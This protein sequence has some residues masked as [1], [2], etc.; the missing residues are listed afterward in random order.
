MLDAL[1]HTESAIRCHAERA[2]MRLL[3]GGCSVPLGVWTVLEAG[4]LKMLGSGAAAAA[5]AAAATCRCRLRRRLGLGRCFVCLIGYLFLPL[6]RPP[7]RL[8]SQPF[9]LPLL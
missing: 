3:E 4:Q 1:N 2:F 9:W 8:P 7:L 5:A 6:L